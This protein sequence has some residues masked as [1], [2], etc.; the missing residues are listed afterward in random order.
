MKESKCRLPNILITDDRLS[1]AER[2]VGH[3]LFGHCSALG[4]CHKSYAALGRL[5][6]CSHETARRAVQRLSELGYI[7]YA[8]TYRYDS[9][10]GVIF[11]KN[12]YCCNLS[13][14]DQGYTIVSRSV[15][16]HKMP[17]STFIIV[18]AVYMEAGNSGRAFPSISFLQKRT[19][20][21]RSTVCAGLR[22]L[23]TLRLVLI[24]LCRKRNGANAA[25]SYFPVHVRHSTAA[26]CPPVA[27]ERP[28]I[29]LSVYLKYIREK[30]KSLL[31]SVCG[32]VRFLANYVRT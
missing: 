30:A 32:A 28:R 7:D 21:A 12:E 1:F 2:K 13:L 4:V 15:F 25:N 14:L 18:L 16:S 9:S 6:G 3:A 20:A 22:L 11:A 5:A 26:V 27:K 19:G 31:F 23:K 10:L 8:N 17:A 24:Q 29:S